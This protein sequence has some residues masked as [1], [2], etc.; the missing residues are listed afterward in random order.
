MRLGLTLARTPNRLFQAFRK[1]RLA[2]VIAVLCGAAAGL[3]IAYFTPPT[4]RASSQLQSGQSAAGIGKGGFGDAEIGFIRSHSLAQKVAESERLNRNARFAAA[5]GVTRV[6]SPGSETQ[7]V[8][9]LRD[10]VGS[11]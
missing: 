11:S 10:R 4:Y 6:G 7:L 9:R 2:L 3:L 5:V 8:D 1:A